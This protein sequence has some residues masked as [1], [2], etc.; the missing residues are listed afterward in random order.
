MTG[1]CS[2]LYFMLLNMPLWPEYKTA[3][4]PGDQLIVIVMDRNVKTKLPFEIDSILPDGS[5]FIKGRDTITLDGLKE[6]IEIN[7]IVRPEDIHSNNT[8]SSKRLS[9]AHIKRNHS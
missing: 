7:A 5:Y 9:M 4:L 8:V 2:L 1:L 3:S 6:D